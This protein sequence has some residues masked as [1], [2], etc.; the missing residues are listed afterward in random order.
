MWSLVVEVHFYILL[1][2]L[3][4]ALH[5]LAKGS[6][7]R[8][9]LILA[10][11]AVASIKIHHLGDGAGHGW[12]AV[13]DSSLPATFFFFVPGMALAVL[14]SEPG[15][16]TFSSLVPRRLASANIWLA[17]AVPFWAVTVASFTLTGEVACAVGSFF[18][19][20]ACV[21]PLRA[22]RL[23]AALDWKPVAALGVASYSFYLWHLPLATWVRHRHL[24]FFGGN[25]PAWLFFVESLVVCVPVAFVSYAIVESPFLRLRRRWWGRPAGSATM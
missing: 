24:E 22:S 20:G 2:L 13:W 6:S 15:G 19:L 14:K 11:L 4:I 23:V 12:A 3:A 16:R 1:P 10:L 18:A 21:L 17:A 8:V 25:P 5:R 9:L 7:R